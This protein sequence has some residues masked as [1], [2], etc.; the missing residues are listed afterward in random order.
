MTWQGVPGREDLCSW[1]NCAAVNLVT[2]RWG[3][4]GGL[5]LLGCGV[6]QLEEDWGPQSLSWDFP[7]VRWPWRR[8]VITADVAGGLGESSA[9]ANPGEKARRDQRDWATGLEARGKGPLPWKTWPV[10]FPKTLQPRR[11]MTCWLGCQ[12][13]DLCPAGP[14]LPSAWNVHT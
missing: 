2:P 12:G 13:G 10:A 9:A 14:N 6:G 11:M 4:S 7:K 8:H 1:L 5:W 3:T